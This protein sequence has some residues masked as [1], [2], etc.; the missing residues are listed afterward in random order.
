MVLRGVAIGAIISA[1]MG[2]V[3]IL[4]VQRTLD[5]GRRHGFYTGIGA[6]ISDLFYCLLTGF[7]LSFIEGFLQDN[8]Q[9]IQI[10]GSVVLI[11]FGIFIM[12]K[13]P[14]R[15]LS[16]PP[17]TAARKGKDV[18]SGFLFT[19]SNP[20]ILFLIIGLFA[21]FNFQSP[22]Y[23][24]YHYVVGYISIVAGAIGWWWLITFAVNKVRAHFNMRSMWIINRII[25]IVILIFALYGL[26]TA[27][28]QD[29]DAVTKAD[30]RLVEYQIPHTSPEPLPAQITA[31]GPQAGRFSFMRS[32]P[33]AESLRG[34]DF[35]ITNRHSSPTKSYSYTDS[36]G[37][38]VKT[39]RPSVSI[40]WQTERGSSGSLRLQ[41]H[42]SVNYQADEVGGETR[43]YCSESG[44]ETQAGILAGLLDHTPVHLDILADRID[45]AVGDA[46]E[47]SFPLD[48]CVVALDIEVAPGGEA[49]VEEAMIWTVAH[50]DYDRRVTEGYWGTSEGRERTL[51]D[52]LN[53]RRAPEV[54][55]VWKLYNT[56]CDDTRMKKGG[57]YDIVILPAKQGGGTLD[58]R[59]LGGATILSDAWR[60][61]RLKG[62]LIP[63]HPGAEASRHLSADD[64]KLEWLDAEGHPCSHDARAHL[65]DGTLT[66]YFPHHKTTL[67]F[68]RQ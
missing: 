23:H 49:T 36:T 16:P 5:G 47:L 3:G 48:G 61:G 21:R 6:A 43:M 56:T 62:R 14:T 17:V 22:N 64:W 60:P 57:D 52:I 26:I 55:G 54:C 10:L 37:R 32:L 59:Y 33:A 4:C 53:G 27:F 11:L 44:T 15:S 30:R 29:A 65:K 38:K 46:K 67:V 24:W 31:P 1:P 39:R 18:L 51:R 28:T 63:D 68:V 13:N 12:R 45:I 34:L 42:E 40:V 19:F 2:P 25:G 50:P 41:S 20:F 66:L 9:I 35:V 58:I 7:G 8:Q